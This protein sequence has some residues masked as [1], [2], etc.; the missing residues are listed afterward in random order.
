[1][2]VRHGQRYLAPGVIGD[3]AGFAVLSG[4]ARRRGARLRHEAL[5]CLASIGVTAVATRATPA[6]RVPEPVLWGMFATGLS[7][8]LRQRRSV[9]R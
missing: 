5:L 1:M 2:Y 7:A 3:L 9:C 4:F 8:Y 6:R